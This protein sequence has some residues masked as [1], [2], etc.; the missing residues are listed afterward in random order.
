MNK[1]IKITALSMALP[2]SLAVNAKGM[3]GMH[4]H[5]GGMNN[6]YSQLDLTEAQKQDVSTI[7]QQAKGSVDRQ[8]RQALRKT[9]LAERSALMNAEQFDED[10]ARAMINNHQQQM[11]EQH[12]EMLKVQ[13][14]M[15]QVLTPEQRTKFEQLMSQGKGRGSQRQ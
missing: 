13:H 1:W 7:M 15:F 9:H 11:I 3:E 2:L 10:K 14:Q 4:G 8:S 12:V 5:R 6:I